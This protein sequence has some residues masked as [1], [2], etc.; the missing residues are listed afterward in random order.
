V[1]GHQLPHGLAGGAAALPLMT[2]TKANG[3]RGRNG[4]EAKDRCDACQ[5]NRLHN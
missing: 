5:C 4:P 3:R 2:D 1:M